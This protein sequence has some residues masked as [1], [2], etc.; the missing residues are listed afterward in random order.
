MINIKPYI[1]IILLSVLCLANSCQAKKHITKTQEETKTVQTS[2]S[3]STT[4]QEKE[5]K[6]DS[7]GVKIDSTKAHD[8]QIII[9]EY[10]RQQ[11]TKDTTGTIKEVNEKYKETKLCVNDTE[12]YINTESSTHEETKEKNTTISENK[13]KENQEQKISNQDKNTKTDLLKYWW[14]LVLIILIL[15]FI[16]KKLRLC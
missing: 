11:V 2:T 13:S 15:Y 6:I 7:T 10:E 16:L 4:K 8:K 12:Y 9:K 5:L 1:Y 14:L 3:S